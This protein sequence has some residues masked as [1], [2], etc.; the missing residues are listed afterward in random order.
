MNR[1]LKIW[2]LLLALTGVGQAAADAPVQPPQPPGGISISPVRI[3][4]QP[5]Q[6]A[7]AI[8]VSNAGSDE[9]L[10]QV[11]TMDWTHP[12]GEDRYV[13]ARGLVV[14]PPLFRLAA[15]ASQVV[16]I[17]LARQVQPDAAV[18]KAFRLFVQELPKQTA[19]QSSQLQMLLR[20]GVPVFIK[21]LQPARA[22]LQWTLS[23]T[24]DAGLALHVHNKGS[25]HERVSNLKLEPGEAIDGFAYVLPGQDRSWI[26][27]QQPDAPLPKTLKAV[28]EG[29]PVNVELAPPAP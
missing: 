26:I 18:E 1:R 17:G 6:H 8:T 21:P 27:K 4:L 3:D 16:R 14:N 2:M 22:D 15:G 29:E 13:P 5:K 25:L 11:E 20:I 24:G 28:T 19:S 9:K 10:I 23:R 7:A 12:M